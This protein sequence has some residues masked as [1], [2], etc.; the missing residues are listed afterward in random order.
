ID[1]YLYALED[2]YRYGEIAYM[3]DYMTKGTASYDT[4]VSNIENDSFPNLTIYEIEVTEYERDG[5][6]IYIYVFSEQLN[7]NWVEYKLVI[8]SHNITLYIPLCAIC[9]D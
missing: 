3:D 9:N 2:M 1:S 4:L 7:F 5:V 8:T 6:D